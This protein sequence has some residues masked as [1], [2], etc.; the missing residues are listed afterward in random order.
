M[1][2]GQPEST[3]ETRQNFEQV[4]AVEQ[5]LQQGDPFTS[6][7]DGHEP[8]AI[9]LTYIPGVHP[10]QLGNAANA[11]QPVY[12]PGPEHVELG[13]LQWSDGSAQQTLQVRTIV[14]MFK[15]KKYKGF[16]AT[17]VD[18]QCLSLVTRTGQRLDLE[19]KSAEQRDNWAAGLVKLLSYVAKQQQLAKQYQAQAK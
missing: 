4:K 10:S 12:Q 15:G 6:Y 16:P 2:G 13:Q 19:A 7:V 17:A 11:Q 1:S 8:R 18:T 3:P 14:D 5:R 9:T